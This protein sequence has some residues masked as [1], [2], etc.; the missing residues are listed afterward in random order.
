MTYCAGMKGT[1]KAIRIL[2]HTA[3]TA[4][5]LALLGPAG[6]IPLPPSVHATTPPTTYNPTATPWLD[7][8]LD[9]QAIA[10]HYDRIAHPGLAQDSWPLLVATCSPTIYAHWEALSSEEKVAAA[11]RQQLC[12]NTL[13]SRHRRDL[14]E[15]LDQAEKLL[16][17]RHPDLETQVRYQTSLGLSGDDVL[18]IRQG[19]GG[20]ERKRTTV[21]EAGGWIARQVQR[22]SKIGSSSWTRGRIIGPF[23]PASPW[24]TDISTSPQQALERLEE[25]V[26]SRGLLAVR[27]PLGWAQSPSD[28]VEIGN[29]LDRVASLIEKRTRMG[30]G[31]FGLWG[32]I[33]LDWRVAD[34][35][36]ANAVTLR[37]GQFYAIQSPE[38][39]VGHEWFHAYSHWLRS[40]GHEDLQDKLL[41]D[42]RGVK[43]N[44]WQ[45]KQIFQQSRQVLAKEQAAQQWIDTLQDLGAA[46]AWE[47]PYQKH[48]QDNTHQQPSIYWYAQAAWTLAPRLNPGE[49]PWISRRRALDET[50][51]A[52]GWT[53]MGIV[54]P[55]YYTENDELVASAFQGD[56][57]LDMVNANLLDSALPNSLVGNPLPVESQ[58][59]RN[60]FSRMFRA[61]EKRRPAQGWN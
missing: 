31:S 20:P 60:A 11:E 25:I 19:L 34:R 18:R 22:Q 26:Q 42:L 33:M 35:V 8:P 6:R 5:V 48:F 54:K 36:E 10:Q 55:G 4:S 46:R 61:N 1:R 45:M 24:G 56:I 21:E 40:K 41:T 15:V 58:A 50:L 32:R 39:A 7:I 38:T 37:A 51:Q 29:R 16:S 28:W 44:R 2:I 23:T 17:Y 49:T 14:H 53:G 13:S 12:K 9:A 57:N 3:M 47:L 30:K 43:Y 52:T 59:M 27:L